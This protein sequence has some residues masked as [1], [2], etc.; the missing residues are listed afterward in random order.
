MPFI[1]V[2]SLPFDP[3]LPMP[4][5]VEGIT[6][7]FAA[8]TDISLEHITATWIFLAPGHY[9]VGGKAQAHQPQTSHPI[10]VDLLSP[11]FNDAARVEKMLYTVAASISKRARI[12]ANN[13]FINHRYA[14]SGMVFDAGKVVRW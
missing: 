6:R 2:T 13:I 14:H 10:L 5:I 9:A 12:P 1:K 3:P 4:E 11:D 8:D 7:D